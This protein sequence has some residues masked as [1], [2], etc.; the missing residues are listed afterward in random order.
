[1]E[2]T[3]LKDST[4]PEESLI[5]KVYKVDAQNRVRIIW[6]C[7]IED[8]LNLIV[9]IRSINT[10]FRLGSVETNGTL[11][12]DTEVFVYSRKETLCHIENVRNNV[13]YSYYVFP[14]KLLEHGQIGIYDQK[15][16]EKNSVTG[17]SIDHTTVNYTQHKGKLYY[18][19]SLLGYFAAC[20][21]LNVIGWI[22]YSIVVKLPISQLDKYPIIEYRYFSLAIIIGCAIW[23]LIFPSGNWSK[24]ARLHITKKSKY[25]DKDIIH[26][27]VSGWS[28]RYSIR[29]TDAS[30]DIVIPLE[31]GETVSFDNQEIQITEITL[32]YLYR[33]Y[34]KNEK[35]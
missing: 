28:E 5:Q 29:L 17:V 30:N 24:R 16:D 26:Y 14:G 11:P 34:I 20:V 35:G 22:I 25:L 23:Y 21:C 9:V 2:Y 13:S 32:K 18:Q 6:D 3:L 12:K 10:G 27:T 8:D 19:Y 1:M 15:I 4:L 33:K 31:S 7:K